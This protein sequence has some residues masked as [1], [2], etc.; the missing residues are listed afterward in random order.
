MVQKYD[1]YETAFA[2]GS[3]LTF[4]APTACSTSDVVAGDF[5]NGI[6]LVIQKAG[7]VALVPGQLSAYDESE[8]MLPFPSTF[9]VI[10]RSKVQD[11]VVVVIEAV[12]TAFSYCSFS[13]VA[14]SG[15]SAAVIKVPLVL[16]G[17]GAAAL[18]LV[19]GE[20]P[21]VVALSQSLKALGVGTNAS[22]LKFAKA[23]EEQGVLSLDRLKKMAVHK[24]K[25]ALE[26]VKMSEFQIDSIMEA[27]TAEAMFETANQRSL[28]YDGY[29]YKSLADH[30]PFST[31]PINEDKKLFTLKPAWHI[32]PNSAETRNVCAGYPWAA[33]TLVFADGSSH[34][35]ANALSWSNRYIE[36]GTAAASFGCLR[37][38]GG[39]YGTRCEWH[40]RTSCDGY[41][42][43]V[44]REDNVVWNPTP[45]FD[46]ESEDDQADHVWFGSPENSLGADDSFRYSDVLIRR[47]IAPEEAAA[48]KSKAAADAHKKE[49]A[50]AEVEAAAAAIKRF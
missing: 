38:E 37:Q 19:Q 36:P 20:D 33:V 1:T 10:A 50:N 14:D 46:W 30:D 2:V 11:T 15:G 16:G 34:F 47:K 24:A 39:R 5:T 3:K 18:S 4:P 29:L 45:L 23:L 48:A 22:C 21:E 31:Q 7:G 28:V 49:I 44:G 13:S 32:C 27:I 9:K 26:V 40:L 41:G 42:G 12:D 17:G 43:W 8:V 6:Q 25:K 35:T